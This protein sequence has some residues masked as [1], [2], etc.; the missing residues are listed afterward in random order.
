MHAELGRGA[1]SDGGGAGRDVAE[2]RPVCASKLCR[3][4]VQD[5]CKRLPS[6]IIIALYSTT[7]NF[8][9][10]SRARQPVRPPARLP[11]EGKAAR[12]V[13]RHASNG[14]GNRARSRL[15]EDADRGQ[16]GCMLHDLFSRVDLEQHWYGCYSAHCYFDVLCKSGFPAQ[17]PI[18]FPILLPPA[19]ARA[20]RSRH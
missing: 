2:G 13:A 3:K 10:S 16:L 18:P 11:G 4:S 5:E 17:L 1:R 9:W 15:G 20:C 19:R 8:G 6:V 7:I 14:H 12:I